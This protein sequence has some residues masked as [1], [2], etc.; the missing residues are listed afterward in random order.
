MPENILHSDLWEILNTE[1]S[2]Y[3]RIPSTKFLF[4][5]LHLKKIE[6]QKLILKC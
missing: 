6:M 3:T 1:F 4:F 5:S 2:L